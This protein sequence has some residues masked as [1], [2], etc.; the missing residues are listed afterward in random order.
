MTTQSQTEIGIESQIPD[1][2][3]IH[4]PIHDAASEIIGRTIISEIC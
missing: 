4:E 3:D 1:I 2:P